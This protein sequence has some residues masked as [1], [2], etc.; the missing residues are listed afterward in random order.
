VGKIYADWA[1]T[2]WFQRVMCEGEELLIPQG[3]PI[4]PGVRLKDCAI[5]SH[6]DPAGSDCSAIVTVAKAPDGRVFILD[7]DCT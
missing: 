5:S 4:E 2:G 6:T 7:I 1:Q 3:I